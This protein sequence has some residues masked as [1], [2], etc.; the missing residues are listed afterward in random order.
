[1][2]IALFKE[3]NQEG[4]EA[5]GYALSAYVCL[6]NGTVWSEATHLISPPVLLDPFKVTLSSRESSSQ[7]S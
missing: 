4:M 6:N 2:L 1:M 7:G 3:Q 5:V